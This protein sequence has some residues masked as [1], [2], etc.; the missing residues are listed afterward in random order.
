M[1]ETFVDKLTATPEGKRGFLQ[2]CAIL[3]VTELICA[4]MDQKN[5]SRA[6][7][8]KRLSKSKGYIT[9]L[10]DG[11]TNMTVRTISDVLWAL[12]CS[13]QVS[14]RPLAAASSEGGITE[15]AKRS[16]D[17]TLAGSGTPGRER[18]IRFRRRTKTA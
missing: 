14:A 11:R 5:V 8:A 6:E 9:Q 18:P 3:E 16:K 17:A 12:D 2:E 4:L 15:R 7:L 13:A 1:G 10:L